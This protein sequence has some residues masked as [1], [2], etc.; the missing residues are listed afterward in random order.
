MEGLNCWEY[1]MC[2]RE[3]GGVNSQEFGACPAS[4]FYK[5][6]GI[7]GGKFSGRY[8]WTVEATLCDTKIKGGIEEKLLS[9]LHC[10]FFKQVNYEEGREFTLM[11]L[12][13]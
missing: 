4:T 3:A 12:E 8:C 7:N 13:K 5:H 10:S 1:F 11:H 9:C 2:G 6:N